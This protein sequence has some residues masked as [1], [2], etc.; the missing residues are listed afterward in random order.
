MKKVYSCLIYYPS[1]YRVFSLSYK[2]V[3]SCVNAR[4]KSGWPET[5]RGST[6]SYTVHVLM[7]TQLSSHASSADEITV[8]LTAVGNTPQSIA[9]VDLTHMIGLVSYYQKKNWEPG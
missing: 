5:G 8:H 3:C 9:Y 7:D 1:K 4:N 2:S 6:R